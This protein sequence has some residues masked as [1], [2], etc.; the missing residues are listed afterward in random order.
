MSGECTWVLDSIVNCWANRTI[1]SGKTRLKVGEWTIFRYLLFTFY[2]GLVLRFSE[3]SSH[4]RQVSPRR[5][6]WWLH[7]LSHWMHLN[8][9]WTLWIKHLPVSKRWLIDYLFGYKGV[10]YSTQHPL[11][12][13]LIRV[14]ALALRMRVVRCYHYWPYWGGSMLWEDRCECLLHWAITPSSM[15][16]SGHW[17]SFSPR[18]WN[19]DWFR[20]ISFNCS[21]KAEALV[22]SFLAAEALLLKENIDYY[23]GSLCI[24]CVCQHEFSS[25]LFAQHTWCEWLRQWAQ[26]WTAAV[27]SRQI[28]TCWQVFGQSGCDWCSF[29]HTVLRAWVLVCLWKWLVTIRYVS[30]K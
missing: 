14:S 19:I 12:I 26:H 3:S 4:L 21:I 7:E 8:W 27:H 13:S 16:Q 2:T 6:L 18:Y 28:A 1:S 20:S 29:D 23:E 30:M 11:L 9:I 10:A 22:S 15:M 25:S 5:M 24:L 17:R